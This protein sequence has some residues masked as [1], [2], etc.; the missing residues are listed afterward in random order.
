MIIKY[1]SLIAAVTLAASASA[2]TQLSES[3]DSSQSLARTLLN[4]GFCAVPN[5][6]IN[7]AC[8][9]TYDAVEHTNHRVRPIL[10]NLVKTDFFRFYYLDLYG[11]SCPLGNDGGTCGNRAC[12]VDTVDDEKDLPVVWRASYL[13]Q[14]VKDT[15][16]SESQIGGLA[17]GDEKDKDSIELSCVTNADDSLASGGRLEKQARDAWDKECKDKNYCVPEDDRTGPN[18]VYV[19]LLDNPERYTGYSGPHAHMMWRS[20]YKQ[21]CF[22]YKGEEF[23]SEFDENL[24]SS[25]EAEP[26][27]P[28]GDECIEQRLFYRLISGMH[29]SVSTHLCYSYLNKQTGEWG[30]DLNCFLSRVGNFPER[31]SNIYFNYALVSRAVSKLYNYIDDLQFCP[32]A[33]AYDQ[34]TRRQILLLTRSASTSPNTF[35]ETSIFS[36][37]EAKLLKEEF[38]QR[39]HKVS[40]LM[41]CVGCDRCRLWGKLQ[42]AGYGTAL[43]IVFELSEKEDELSRKLIASLRRS[44]LVSLINTFDRLSKSI[45]AVEYFREQTLVDLEASGVSLDDLVSNTKQSEIPTK[46]DAVNNEKDAEDE[47]EDEDEEEDQEPQPYSIWNDPEW[48]LWKEAFIFL[49]RSYIDFPKNLY[50]ILLLNA[51]YYWD[52]M[53]GRNEADAKDRVGRRGHLESIR[54]DL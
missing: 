31:L 41:D 43:K 7:D 39:F 46:K 2:S 37:P 30:P 19:S 36:T 40:A 38:R 16:A 51:H 24:P 32:Q 22:G 9:A 5:G 50:N 34:A 13:G 47:D 48:D 44:E 26:L 35:N 21:N 11:D 52:A 8:G 25:A 45:E 6:S 12:A 14:L 33:Q 4:P 3:Q 53:I 17:D 28:E 18:G 42:A 49:W 54:V 20:V 29:A 23:S 10:Q 15:V 1:T 27:V